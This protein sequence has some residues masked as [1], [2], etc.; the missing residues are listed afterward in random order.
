MLILEK[1]KGQP[2]ITA[3]ETDYILRWRRWRKAPEVD[4]FFYHQL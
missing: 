4:I 2:E 3:V 1:Q